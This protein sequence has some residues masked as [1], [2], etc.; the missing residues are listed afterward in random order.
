MSGACRIGADKKNSDAG[1]PCFGPSAQ[2][3]L[4][5][6]SKEFS[7][8]FM[9]KHSIP[10]ARYQVWVLFRRVTQYDIATERLNRAFLR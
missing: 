3:A 6:A 5:E 9:S 10:T 8:S 2:A 4:I 1:V 7:K